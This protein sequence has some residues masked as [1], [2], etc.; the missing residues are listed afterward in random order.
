MER[1]EKNKVVKM[2]Y[3]L[4]DESGNVLEETGDEPVSFIFGVG[5]II[6]GLERGMEG[7][8]VGE[9]RT[10]EVSPLDGYGEYDETAVQE[11][12]KSLFG[13][14]EPEVGMKFYAQTNDGHSI[15]VYIKEVKEDSV[16]I[17]FNHPLAGKNLKFKVKVVGIRD[18]TEEELEH[19]HIHEEFNFGGLEE[20]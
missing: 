10:I 9:E 11:V 5:Q 6:E 18:A 19:G 12:P 14:T 20:A 13:D 1:V 7:M 2:T 4:M 17:D 16:I 8:V 15:P 3:I